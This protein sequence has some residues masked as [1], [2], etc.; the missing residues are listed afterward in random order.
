MKKLTTYIGKTWK[1]GILLTAGV[2]FLAGTVF[3]CCLS[4]TIQVSVSHKACCHKN[5][6]SN[7]DHSTTCDHCKIQSVSDITKAFDF[8]PSLAKSLPFFGTVDALVYL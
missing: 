4:K 7:A 2:V 1:A 5:K 3:C 6:A 8:V